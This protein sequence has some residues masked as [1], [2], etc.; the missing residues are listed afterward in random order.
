M[1]QSR[2]N[3]L[4]LL[5]LPILLL[6]SLT[7]CWS[8]RELEDLNISIGLAID[9][10]KKDAIERGF[11]KQNGNY[12]KKDV[13]TLTHQL[14]NTKATSSES[15]GGSQQKSYINISVSGDSYLQLLREVSIK[16]DRPI[17][18][19]HTKVI[20]IGDAIARRNGLDQLLD[21]FF[22]DNEMRPSCQVFISKGRAIDTLESKKPGVIPA[23]RLL[24]IA[25]NQYKTTKILPPMS[26]GKTESQL[27]SGSSFLLQNVIS[28]DGEIKLSGAAVINGKTKKLEGFLSEAEVEGITWITGK[29]KGGLVKIRDKKTGQVI[30]Y[31]IKSMKSKITPHVVN[32][33]VQSFDMKI[34]SEGRISENWNG[35]APHGKNFR[36]STEKTVE[37]EVNRLIKNTLV[38]MQ[39]KFHV[40][41]AGFGNQV[42]IEYPR[43]WERGKKDWDQTFSEVPIKYTVDLTITD[44]GGSGYK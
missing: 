41:V 33:K 25:D 18:F 31:E 22:R 11:E 12:P 23:N 28:T 9:K 35:E 15:K 37:E 5:S 16:N 20:V 19:H 21:L 2:N 36:K 44:F 30:I 3:K 26:L 7:G 10:A 6:F 43:V 29:G 17:I 24:G 32:G 1:K 14:V 39:E 27:L 8:S 34:K 40:D 13:I 4:F 38:T 42:R